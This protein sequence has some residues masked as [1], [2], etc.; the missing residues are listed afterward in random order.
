[1]NC[2][3]C[4]NE[5]QPEEIFCGQCG[6]ATLASVF[7]TS[8]V[9]GNEDLSSSQKNAFTPP[10]RIH[11]PHPQTPSTQ[12]PPHPQIRNLFSPPGGLFTSHHPSQGM[13]GSQQGTIGVQQ[14]H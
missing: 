12:T 6:T 4:G 14:H 10:E 2:Q 7:P 3:R 5:V 1:M 11:T 8:M 13:P 9:L